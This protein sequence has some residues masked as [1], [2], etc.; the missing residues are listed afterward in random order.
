M[1]FKLF[2]LSTFKGLKNTAKVEAH[3]DA[4]W[5]D[6]LQYRELQNSADLKEYL[7]LE[8]LINS[9]VFKKELKEV[10]QLKFDGSPESKLLHEYEK[11]DRDAKLKNL[12]LT[13]S[14]A[15]FQKF[16]Q[17]EKSADVKRYVELRD[18]VQNKK[19]EA[20]KAAWKS[21][22]NGKTESFE[23][24]EA[25]QKFESY[26]KL[27][28]SEPILFWEEYPKRKEYKDYL[29]TANSSTRSHFEEL[30]GKVAAPE[31]QSRVEFLKDSNRWEKT[32]LFQ[33]EKRYLELKGQSRFQVYEKYR[34]PEALSF[35]MNHDLL[36][37][38]NF[39]GG[40]LDLARWKTI[41]PLAET[42]LGR[43]FSKAGDL[44]AYTEGANVLQADSKL[45]LAVK[46][47]K[48]ESM[49]WNFP[50]GF[51]PVSFD[52]SAGLLCSSESFCI[53]DG[54]LE[55]KIR[56]QPNKKL[57]DLFYLADDKG[58]FRLN[59]L[60]SGVVSRFGLTDS[61]KEENEALGGLAAGQF[62][63]F[64]VEWSK[65]RVCWK[66]NGHEIYSL[67]Q[68]VPDK[69]LHIHLSSIVVDA[70]GELPHFF[71]ID[72]VRLYGKK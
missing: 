40:K 71:E 20:D 19:Y 50:V 47:E 52:Y 39:E 15:D 67:N 35:F 24:T 13:E 28:S 33:K 22:Q 1:S 43:N 64:R 4:L 59:L 9:A 41:S 11:L 60:E 42:T 69:A 48:T 16:S 53:Q 58:T 18:Y 31:F 27:K 49:V 54:A 26:Q 62:Y 66:I 14:S 57:V 17:L 7:E 65:G 3:R 63:I 29:Q 55:A 30:K 61:G 38:D 8:Q 51:S 72:W 25:H 23:A 34:N 32:E 56:F 45:K 10:S 46:K 6:Y 21:K 44:Q 70:P 68:S 5:A 37:E 12:Y 36:L 2:F